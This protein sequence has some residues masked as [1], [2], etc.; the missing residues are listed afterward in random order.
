M[1]KKDQIRKILTDGHPHSAKELIGI[2][3]RFSAVIHSLREEGYRI[4][5]IALAHN[6]FAYQLLSKAVV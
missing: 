1:S 5:T 3:H 2:T 6:E 4:E